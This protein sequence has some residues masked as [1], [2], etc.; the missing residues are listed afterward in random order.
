MKDET[1]T[2]AT[3]ERDGALRKLEVY[4]DRE[5]WLE[6][7]R[8][9][10]GSSDITAICGES[11]Y[12]SPFSVWAEKTGREVPAHDEESELLEWGHRNEEVIAAK[13][14]EVLRKEV[15]ERIVL[16]DPGDFAIC[17]APASVPVPASATLDREAFLRVEDFSGLSDTQ[18]IHPGGT[19]PYAVVEL[20][21]SSSWME[22][23]WREEIPIS[24]TLQAQWQ[25][26]VTGHDLAFVAALIGGNRFRWAR[27]ETDDN[28]R[29]ILLSIAA[30][31][32]EQVETDSPPP[33]D[34]L[35]VTRRAL[36]ARY[37]KGGDG[38]TVALR[39]EASQ[40]WHCRAAAKA[41][42]KE[43]KSIVD[44]ATNDL[45]AAI[46]D[47]SAGRLEDGTVINATRVNVKES[48]PKPRKAYSFI[49]IGKQRG[50]GS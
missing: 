2:T 3:D 12:A 16:R 7:R 35:A 5:S 30:E 50:S 36:V 28:L 29:E 25:M 45:V 20:K 40:A 11:R 43:D 4:K 9:S 21:N 44:K 22:A 27:L 6:A 34:G 48:E 15:D 37:G 13:M 49:R 46:G 38:T 32:W 8:L 14:G 17:R 26:I 33:V 42:I 31:F 39:D 24:V 23:R 10:I 19:V 41:R 1:T 18:P 47:H